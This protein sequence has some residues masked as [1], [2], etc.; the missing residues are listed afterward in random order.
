MMNF[1]K[2]IES[3]L[4]KEDVKDEIINMI[5]DETGVMDEEEV[6]SMNTSSLSNE[7][8]DSIISQLSITNP[9]IIEKIKSGVKIEDIF[10]MSK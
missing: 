4:L 3:K 9:D 7:I 2:F 6:M 8:I 10:I 5:S 1:K